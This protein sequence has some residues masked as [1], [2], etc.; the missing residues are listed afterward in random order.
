V[1]PSLFTLD[2]S[3]AAMFRVDGEQIKP[4]VPAIIP[5]SGNAVMTTYDESAEKKEASLDSASSA[6]HESVKAINTNPESFFNF[7]HAPT[8]TYH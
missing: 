7:M 6:E 2:E 3:T 8:I 4:I 5:L 1:N